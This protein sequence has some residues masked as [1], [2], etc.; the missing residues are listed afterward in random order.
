MRVRGERERRHRAAFLGKERTY[1]ADQ[2]VPDSIDPNVTAEDVARHLQ[3]CT[4][5]RAGLERARRTGPV[6][7][8]TWRREFVECFSRRRPS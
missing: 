8:A 7:L 6:A 1:L 5:C 4:T 3:Q 2:R